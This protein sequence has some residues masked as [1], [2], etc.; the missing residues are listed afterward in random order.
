MHGGRNTILTTDRSGERAAVDAAAV[1][2]QRTITLSNGIVLSLRPVPVRLIREATARVERPKVPV[3]YIADGDR[4]EEN[5]DD[6]AY[7]Q[8]LSEWSVAVSEAAA[9]MGVMYGTRVVSVPDGYERPE[10]DAWIEDTE[11][12]FAAT[13]V[14]VK[15]RR[16][17]ERARYYDWIR[18][19]AAADEIDLFMLTR[20][21]TS[22]YMLS[23]EEVAAAV[24]TFRRLIG[25][26]ADPGS[27][28]AAA[29]GI[30]GDRGASDSAGVGAGVGPAS[31][32][33]AQSDPVDDVGEDATV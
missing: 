23:E 33:E 18:Y 11:A 10:S 19:Y 12:V 13:G 29:V 22:G 6:P 28:A 17:P 21:T 14:E 16:E 5:P 7:Q 8:A 30:D 32:S 15:V 3:V 1:S 4:H 24:A 9:T 20:H 26:P 25:R 2:T 27:A 31:G